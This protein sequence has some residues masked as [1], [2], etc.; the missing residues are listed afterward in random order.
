MLTHY[1]WPYNEAPSGGDNRNYER[2]RPP[3]GLEPATS[4]TNSPS[5][6]QISRLNHSATS[7]TLKGLVRWTVLRLVLTCTQSRKLIPWVFRIFEGHNFP[8][9]RLIE[10]LTHYIWP[11]NVYPIRGR[12][13]KL[14]KMHAPVGVRTRDLWH[15]PPST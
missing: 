14:R 10:M 5:T 2:C 13:S 1:I 3:S 15:Q 8:C 6:W 11:Y 7:P 12:L 4:G 9:P